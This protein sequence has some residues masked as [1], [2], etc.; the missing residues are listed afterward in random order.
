M[1]TFIAAT[2]LVANTFATEITHHMEAKMLT[3]VETM[4]EEMITLA[5]VHAMVEAECSC[6]DHSS[7][8]DDSH[9]HS[10]GC[11]H[12]NSCCRPRRKCCCDSDS[13]STSSSSS[14]SS[15]ISVITEPPTP[16]SATDCYDEVC[17]QY[18]PDPANPFNMDITGMMLFEVSVNFDTN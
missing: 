14:S 7:D 1:K 13:S 18:V 6:Q 11:H 2:L 16:S 12:H 17:P 4:V 3:E 10:C 9:S 5:E 15:S 8:S